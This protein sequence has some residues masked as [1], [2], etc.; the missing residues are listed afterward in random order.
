MANDE[1][2]ALLKLGA[3]A[4]AIAAFILKGEI[5]AAIEPFAVA[6]FSPRKED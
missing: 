6:K 3:T 1:H 5:T 2:V 4:A